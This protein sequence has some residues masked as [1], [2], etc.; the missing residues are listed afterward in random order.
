LLRNTL[1]ERLLVDEL[2]LLD[3]LLLLDVLVRDCDTFGVDCRAKDCVGVDWR[4]YEEFA[5][6]G[7][8]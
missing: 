3:V 2:A 1:P 4:E 8:E 5:E 6:D 7:F